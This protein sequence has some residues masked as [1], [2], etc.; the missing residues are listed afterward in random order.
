MVVTAGMGGTAAVEAVKAPPVPGMQKPPHRV[1]KRF[2]DH[3]EAAL[4]EVKIPAGLKTR[5]SW[6]Q[7]DRLGACPA[8][9][10]GA[11]TARLGVPGC[12]G[13]E[14]ADSDDIILR[15]DSAGEGAGPRRRTAKGPS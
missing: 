10:R 5:P 11:R 9:G 2:R 14:A 15:P 7:Q 4:K 3:L 8:V 12:P 1:G 13:L 6:R